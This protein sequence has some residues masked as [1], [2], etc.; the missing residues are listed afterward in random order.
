MP[1]IDLTL[2]KKLDTSGGELPIIMAAAAAAG[3]KG[4]GSG[5]A[6]ADGSGGPAE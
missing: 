6:A 4:K 3:G 1:R 5:A 2:A